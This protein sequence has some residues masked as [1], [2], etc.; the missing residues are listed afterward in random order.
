MFWSSTS[1][2]YMSLCMI[3][4]HFSVEDAVIFCEFYNKVIIV[5]EELI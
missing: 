2:F 5:G 1:D 4:C 3:I